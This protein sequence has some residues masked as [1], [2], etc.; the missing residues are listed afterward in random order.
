MVTHPVC[1]L[2]RRVEIEVKAPGAQVD[3]QMVDT[4]TTED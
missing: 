3:T 2:D 4:D 1:G